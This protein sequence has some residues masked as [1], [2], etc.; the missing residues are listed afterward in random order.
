MIPG[1]KISWRQAWLPTPVFLPGEFRWQ[2]SLVGYSAWGYK[3]ADTIEQIVHAPVLLFS[4]ENNT[5]HLYIARAL[6]K[7][8]PKLKVDGVF[9]R[10]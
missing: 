8:T 3:E 5:H 2:R 4:D 7:V 6:I 10:L 9:S 1:S